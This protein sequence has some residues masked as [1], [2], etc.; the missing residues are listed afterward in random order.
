MEKRVAWVTTIMRALMLVALGTSVALLLDYTS[1]E[2]AFC[3]GGSG[4]AEVRASGYGHLPLGPVMLPVPALG[5]TAFAS[6]FFVSFFVARAAWLSVLRVAVSL[7]ALSALVF[8]A[9]QAKMGHFCVLCLVVDGAALLVV[10]LPFL[11]PNKP[12]GRPAG[13]RLTTP[14]WMGLLGLSLLAPLLFPRV[15]KPNP[16][17][18]VIVSMYRPGE[19]TVLEFFDFQCPHCRHLSP[20]LKKIVGEF[21]QAK[22]LYGYTPLP[23]HEGAHI[24]ARLTI[25]AA[26]QDKEA[27]LAE[28]FFVQ[29]DFSDDALLKTA[30]EEIPDQE[31][32]RECLASSR[33][34]DRIQND[35]A[36]IR[37]AGFVGLPTTY[38]G[39]LRLLGVQDT[40]AYRDAISKASAG[41]DRSGLPGWA[42]WVLVGLLVALVAAFGRDKTNPLATGASSSTT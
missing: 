24:A 36:A 31:A 1:P 39:G 11:L 8:I 20:E 3:G 25:C 34:D 40:M 28:R 29:E 27:Q 14:A 37:A 9:L 17:P 41:K 23:G 38:V 32:L 21:P 4:C 42:Y 6:L 12:Q 30:L 7:G 33:P 2:P 18:P 13:F 16:V 15:V 5:V 26:E 10:P 19:V 35:I 22:L